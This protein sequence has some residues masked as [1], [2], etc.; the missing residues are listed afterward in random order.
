MTGIPTD[1]FRQKFEKYLQKA[2]P[3]FEGLDERELEIENSELEEIA[4][5]YREMAYSYFKDAIYFYEKEEYVNALGALEYAEGWYD[6]G[7]CIGF[8][9]KNKKED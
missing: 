9:K 7:C 8:F 2:S 5:H 3:W 4:E 6:A 1:K